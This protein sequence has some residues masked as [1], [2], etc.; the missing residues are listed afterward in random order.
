MLIL[1]QTEIISGPLYK[2]LAM[3]VFFSIV[4]LCFPSGILFLEEVFFDSEKMDS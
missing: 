2:I 1:I 4:M 3:L